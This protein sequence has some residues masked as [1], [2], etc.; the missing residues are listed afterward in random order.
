MTPDQ[1]DRLAAER[2]RELQ[3]DIER[4]RRLINS[5]NIL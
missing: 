1:I 2:E 5:R 3:A 4:L